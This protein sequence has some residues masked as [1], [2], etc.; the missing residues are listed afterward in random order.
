MLGYVYMYMY[1]FVNMIPIHL[2]STNTSNMDTV[3]QYRL[4]SK[5][6]EGNL[7]PRLKELLIVKMFLLVLL[8]SLD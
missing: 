3:Q 7:M 8:I 4:P 5:Q 1:P 2:S 6:H